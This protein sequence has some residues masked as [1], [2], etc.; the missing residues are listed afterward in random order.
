M[1]VRWGRV[2]VALLLLLFGCGL[3]TLVLGQYLWGSTGGSITDRV[4]DVVGGEVEGVTPYVQGTRD[5]GGG[6]GGTGSGAPAS[7]A[8]GA[9]RTSPP[10]SSYPEPSAEL[11]AFTVLTLQY[12]PY[13]ATLA[14]M[15][16]GGY[17]EAE[18]YDLQLVDVYAEDVGLD[19]AGQ[20]EALKAGEYQALA[21]TLDATRKCGPGAAVA[22]PIGQSAGNDAIVVKP[23]VETWNDIFEHAVAFTGY[24]VSE[25]MACFAS[26]SA[27]AAIALPVR[28]DDAAAAVDAWIN[29]GAEQNILSVVAWEPELSRALEAV[30]GSRAILSSRDVRILWDVLQVGSAQFAENPAP[31]QAFARAYYAALKDLTQSPDA[32]LARIVEWAGDDPARLALLTTT[33]PA[34]FRAD[35]D[36]EAFAT[37]RDASILMDH[38]QTLVN[39][40][41]EAAFYWEYCGVPVPPAEN[42]EA[43][44]LPDLVQTAFAD[45]S[46]VDAPEARPSAELFQVSD[47]TNA[48]AV[49]DQQIQEAR[50]L[51]EKGVEIEF[52]A[53]R[54]DFRQPAEALATLGEAVRFL[55]TC[56][57]CVLQVQGGAAY[58]GARIC[59]TCQPA[60]SDALAVAR[61]QRVYEELLARFDVPE[62]QLHLVTEPR[63]PQFAGSN[64]ESQLRQDRRT[65]LTGY[66]LGGR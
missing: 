39:R 38:R 13:M 64:D 44:I 58:P 29:E 53:N 63:A 57:D 30:P 33:D 41:D 52:L 55:R 49:T 15:E 11:P 22:I 24:S 23:G 59:P 45:G 51:F 43:L 61:G 28:T 17:L 34:A 2:V 26:H 7:G 25:Y 31:Y 5:A 35:L 12:T 48:S 32:A 6:A 37:L 1:R 36:R 3:L 20:C 8:A 14:H 42:P 19:E 56:Q 62:A 65:F 60:D 54:T 50:V 4:G 47:F 27:N 66:Q 46:L 21:T 9:G 16:A 18:G 40:L 10:G